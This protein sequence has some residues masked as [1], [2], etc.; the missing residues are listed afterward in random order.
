M[1]YE[2]CFNQFSKKNN[3]NIKLRIGI[4]YRAFMKVYKSSQLYLIKIVTLFLVVLINQKG[5]AQT[6][7]EQSLLECLHTAQNDT[8]KQYYHGKLMWHYYTTDAAKCAY[9]LVERHAACKT[10][11]AFNDWSL[12]ETYYSVELFAD[13]AKAI[14]KELLKLAAYYHDKKDPIRE[15]EALWANATL[16]HNKDSAV[17]NFIRI[18]KIASE[19]NLIGLIKRM[20]EVAI[21]SELNNPDKMKKMFVLL[22]NK[23]KNKQM[24]EYYWNSFYLGQYYYEQGR[25]DSAMKY[26][27]E[28]W[29]GLNKLGFRKEI[30]FEYA[31]E[32]IEINGY[33]QPDD[34]IYEANKKWFAF[35]EQVLPLIHSQQTLFHYYKLIALN[36]T[37]ARDSVK[38]E[39]T[40]NKIREIISLQKD[41]KT[42]A[43]QRRDLLMT[44]AQSAYFLGSY[45]K[46]FEHL[47]Q[48][49]VLSDSIQMAENNDNYNKQVGQYNLEKKEYEIKLAKIEKNKTIYIAIAAGLFIVLSAIA[50]FIFITYR[51][52]INQLKKMV[53]VRNAIAT[54]LH[55]EVGSTLSSISM[56]S[57]MA[58]KQNNNQLLETISKN[59]QQM[60]DSMSDIVWCINPNNDKLEDMLTRMRLFA[61]DILEE[62]DVAITFNVPEQVERLQIPMELRKD[63][64]LIYKEAVNNI[65]KYANATKVTINLSSQSNQLNLQI[66]DN[67]KGFETSTTQ[68]FGGNGLRNMKQRAANLKGDIHINSSLQ[69]GTTILLHVPLT[70]S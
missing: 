54:D 15:I 57:Q 38:A 53:Q 31:L 10:W 60:L 2:F 30:L 29:E 42:N 64:Y 34:K 32:L 56:M 69:S 50:I 13:Y 68:S 51:N 4:N 23:L 41:S 36:Y 20:D 1:D 66:T 35:C 48:R 24:C 21:A 65:A 17:T 5:L 12:K 61:S 70:T 43:W 49:I 25:L 33:T 26:E 6:E 52:R 63:I 59:S 46:G 27:F 58:Q 7:T 39:Q 47:A 44:M 19:A 18:N 45:K 55:D 62:K 14:N 11:P 67:G 40:F 3:Q 37:A 22:N 8:V 9:H 28:A 16:L